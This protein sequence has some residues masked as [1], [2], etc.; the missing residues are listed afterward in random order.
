MLGCRGCAATAAAA[1]AAAAVASAAA[2]ATAATAAADATAAAP[3]PL[4]LLLLLLLLLMLLPA[5]D[6]NPKRFFT[7]H[8]PFEFHI[9]KTSV[10]AE[11]KTRPSLP[12]QGEHDPPANR[13]NTI[14]MK[15]LIFH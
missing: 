12:L 7:F 15:I 11:R 5:A 9:A 6:G 3:P 14:F 2:A 4:L 13:A 8:E 10:A 1:A